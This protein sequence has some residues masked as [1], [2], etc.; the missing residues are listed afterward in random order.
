[1]GNAMDKR[2]MPA[3]LH[4]PGGKIMGMTIKIQEYIGYISF[5]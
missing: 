1:M 3:H 5:A 2:A 4:L